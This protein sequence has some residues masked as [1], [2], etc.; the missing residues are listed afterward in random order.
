[1]SNTRN[2]GILTAP[3]GFLLACCL[4]PL[5]LN[6]LIFVGTS[7]GSPQNIVSLYGQLFAVRISNLGASTYIITVQLACALV[8]ALIVFFV[9][10][11]LL[12]QARQTGSTTNP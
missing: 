6:N 8:A 12:L 2:V 9:G 1:M 7:F 10:V 3:L 5:V 11:M 4:C